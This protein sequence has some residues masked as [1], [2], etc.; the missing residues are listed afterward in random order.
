MP[1]LLLANVKQ[2]KFLLLG[3]D[4]S[5]V[6]VNFEEKLKYKTIPLP[7]VSVSLQLYTVITYLRCVYVS[8]SARLL[9]VLLA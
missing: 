4:C 7:H 2:F 5:L 9:T 3:V 6:A 1:T 8:D